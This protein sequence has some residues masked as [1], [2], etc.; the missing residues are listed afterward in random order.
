MS[1]KLTQELKLSQ[2]LIMTPQL[3]M[4]IKL[5]QLSRLELMDAIHQELVENPALEE[6]QETA[7]DAT[8]AEKAESQSEESQSTKEI[9]IEERIP[10]EMDWSNYI[11]EFNTP[12]RFR[13]ETERKERINFESFTAKKESLK[14]HLLWQLLMT[15]PTE[16]E[17]KIGSLIVGNLNR[18]G[19]LDIT[20]EDLVKTSACTPEK[21]QQVL[22]RLQ[23]FDPIGVC[24]RNLKECL[25]I[26]VSRLGLENSL[27]TDIVQNHI[28]HLENK[29]YKVISKALKTSL[30]SVISAVNIIKGLEP[31]PGREFSD[32][33]QRYITPDIY[34]H[35]FDD[36]FLITLNDDGLPRLRINSYYQNAVKQGK[37][38]TDTEKEYLQDKLRSAAWLIR[39]IHQ[40]QK[41]HLQGHDKYFAFS[42][43]F[44]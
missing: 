1:L 15:F 30:E 20:V 38:L 29:N 32:E 6:I 26:Q 28:N 13:M 14:D 12:G 7:S 16:N 33:V 3:Q 18:D 31:K 9:T 5:L 17:E 37:T 19:Y 42:T 10:D 44:F 22:T 2:Q 4:A 36:E 11:D 24:A 23:T 39:S 8:V 27:V 25:L 41:N 34:V 35:K 40:R 21:V 43:R